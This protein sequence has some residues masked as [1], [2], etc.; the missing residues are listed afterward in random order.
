MEFEILTANY[1]N[2]QFL[3]SFFN[4]INN[5]F[6]KPKRI[7]FVDDCSTDNSIEIVS[8]FIK[9]GNVPVKLIENPENMGFANS[10][11]LAISQLGST[12]FARLDPDDSVFPERFQ[13]QL[14]YLERNPDI[15][16]V[17]TNVQYY[18]NNLPIRYSDVMY[19]EFKIKNAIKRGILP[20]IHG[21]IMGRSEILKNYKYDQ[22]LVPS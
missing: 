8:K 4:S 22:N 11:N 19:G 5:S 20:I 3:D 10:L 13:A 2:S 16:L 1:N 14:L 7:I 9:E 21:T 15:D 6:V 18:L 17:G 12:Y